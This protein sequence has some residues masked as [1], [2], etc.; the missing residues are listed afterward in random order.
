MPYEIF[1]TP[2]A[3]RQLKKLPVNVGSDIRL[4]LDFLSKDP[5]A[6][7]VNVKKLQGRGGYRLRIGNYRV[8]YELE[9]KKL[10]IYVLEVAHRKDIYA[11]N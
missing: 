2:Y 7:D 11:R 10:I 8:I 4:A 3:R 9:N 1:I 6:D 5:F